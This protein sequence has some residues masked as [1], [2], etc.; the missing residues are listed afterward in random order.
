MHTSDVSFIY[1]NILQLSATHVSIFRE[2]I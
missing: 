1:S 2:V